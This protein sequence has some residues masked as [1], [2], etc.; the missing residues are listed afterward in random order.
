[1][2]K[3]ITS[4]ATIILGDPVSLAEKH[5]QSNSWPLI[6][7]IVKIKIK[8]TSNPLIIKAAERG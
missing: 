7:L 2:I 1:M 3:Y 5:P 4:L 6:I 8:A